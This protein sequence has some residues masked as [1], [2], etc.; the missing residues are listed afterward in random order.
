MKKIATLF[1]FL[2]YL[3]LSAQVEEEVVPPYNIKTVSFVLKNSNTVPIFKYGESFELQFDDLFAN[4][5]SYFYT[6]VH[7]DYDW[8]P[9]DIPKSEYIRG[10]DNLRIQD[11]VSS[12][13]TL[14]SYTHYSLTLPN[15]NTQILISGNY[16]L[17]ILDENK[18][19]VFSRKFVIYNELTTVSGTTHRPRTGNDLNTK[20][21]IDFSV[22][23]TIMSFQNPTKNL[24]IVLLQ[25][26]QF[27]TAIK[28]IAPQYTI[29]DEFIYKYN[30]ETQFWAGNEYLYFDSKKLNSV[31][32]T[33][34]R[35]DNAN[36]MYSLYLRTNNARANFPYSYTQDVNGSFV[37]RNE[38]STESETEAD[39]FWVY[40]SLSAPSFMLNKELYVS[41]GF[42]NY[43]LS[44]DNKMEYNAKNNLYEKALLVKQG[45]TNYQYVIADSKGK[46]DNENAIDGNFWE[47]ENDYTIIVYYC[48]DGARYNKVVGKAVVS[49]IGITN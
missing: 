14:Q 49:S 37:V 47:T 5:A 43:S 15:S 44:P 17:S 10:F 32:N 20:Q 38:S 41:G 29:G 30:T 45:F 35:I 8:I 22:T 2:S 26:G 34:S 1:L 18:D 25:N 31:T 23:S 28:N 11:E 46:I 42:N 9:T 6:I 40:F 12:V 36:G 7:C 33:I 48:E 4:D 19:V 24:K 27:N 16:M 39:Y 13:N 21:N 3:S